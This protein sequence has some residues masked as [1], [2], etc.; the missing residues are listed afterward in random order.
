VSATPYH[1]QFFTATILEWKHLLKPD[2]YKEIIIDSLR[3]LTKEKRAEVF[4][5]MIMSNQM[6]LIWQVQEGNRK[7]NVQRGF[8]K[9]TGQ[10]IKD[11]LIKNHPKVLAHFESG[12]RDRKYQFW[13]RNSLSVDLYSEAVFMQKLEYI[14]LNPVKAG[15]CI[16]PEEYKYSSAKFMK[17]GLTSMAS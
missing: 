5:H 8:L 3:L 9:F 17:R 11:D 2:K 16:L 15:L 1:P 10:R 12:A 4:A 14:H 7:E 6:H 13:E